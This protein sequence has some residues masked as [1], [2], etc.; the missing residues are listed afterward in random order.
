MPCTYIIVTLNIHG[1]SSTARMGMLEGFLQT[2]DIDIALLQEVT[3]ANFSAIR[4]YTACVK[5][6]TERRRKAILAEEGLTLS[7]IQRLPSRMGISATYS[8]IRVIN[9]HASSGADRKAE[10]ESFYNK[11]TM[12]LLPLTRTEL[13]LAGEFNCVISNDDCTGQRSRSR[14]LND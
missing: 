5:E 2:H 6:G 13:I 14:A 3:H 1:I 12:H 8:S 9:I 10:R 7:N 4:R 11:D